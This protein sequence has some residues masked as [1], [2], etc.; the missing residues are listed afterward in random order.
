[1]CNL[2]VDSYLDNCGLLVA[3]L[4]RVGEACVNHFSDNRL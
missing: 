2:A 1:M 4:K 3:A